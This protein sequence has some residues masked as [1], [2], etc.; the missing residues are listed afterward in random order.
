MQQRFTDTGHIAV[1]ENPEHPGEER[2]LPAIA[3]HVLR[4][5]EPEEGLSD[6]EA[7]S[8]SHDG[9]LAR[10]SRFAAEAG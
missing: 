9:R 2:M 10:R 7:V 4:G 8:G 3:P 5:K 6:S 1:S